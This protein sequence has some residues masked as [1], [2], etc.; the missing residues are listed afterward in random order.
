MDRR[1]LLALLREYEAS[2]PEHL[3][4]GSLDETVLASMLE[5]PNAGLTATD[6]TM[7]VGCVFLTHLDDESVVLQRLYV[8]PAARG[9][10]HGRALVNAA[11]SHARNARY[12]RIVLDTQR[13]ALPEA[14]ALYVRLG[15][16]ECPPFMP[17]SYDRVSYMELPLR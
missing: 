2:L 3:R 12:R 13:D 8:S 1:A 17:V 10:G 5:P 7:L 14:Y 16:R 9:S 4:H 15:F 11:I 6:G